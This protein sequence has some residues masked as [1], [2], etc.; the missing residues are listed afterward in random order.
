MEGPLKIILFDAVIYLVTFK[1]TLCNNK[2]LKRFIRTI[3]HLSDIHN[4]HGAY[5][6]SQSITNNLFVR[7]VNYIS[8]T[9]KIVTK[10]CIQSVIRL[11]I[12]PSYRLSTLILLP[13]VLYTYQRCS[14]PLSL[15]DET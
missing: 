15:L 9:S 10:R 1:F 12:D 6:F 4:V 7:R 2:T 3:C 8:P 5:F 11:L 14:R 13:R